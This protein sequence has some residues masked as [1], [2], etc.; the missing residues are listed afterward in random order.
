MSHI[1]QFGFK[2]MAALG[3]YSL[4]RLGAARVGWKWVYNTF[5]KASSEGAGLSVYNATAKLWELSAKQVA[6]GGSRSAFASAKL[7]NKAQTKVIGRLKA[8]LKSQ[9]ALGSS[10]KLLDDAGN[11]VVGK[12]K[13]VSKLVQQISK[14]RAKA[15]IS[16]TTIKT[17]IA[18]FTKR[19]GLA[20]WGIKAFNYAGWAYL[21]WEVLSTVWNI[22]D[23]TA[24]YKINVAQLLAGENQF[25]WV[26][27]TYKGEDYVAGLEGIIG[28]PRSTSTI[29][30]GELK[31]K[32]GRNRAIYILGQMWDA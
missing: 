24:Y 1:Q 28:T 7:A 6:D 4:I 3:A 13:E 14:L 16:K 30:H 10:G 19:G 9:M 22:M 32:E 11:L 8:K 27:L 5:L 23:K 31:G 20:S 26:P 25:T 29:I 17:T 18:S 12:E 2:N 15:L 21:A